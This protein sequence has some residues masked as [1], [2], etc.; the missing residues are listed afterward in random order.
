MNVLTVNNLTK[1][2]PSFKLDAVSFSL[3]EGKITGFIGRNGAGKST[4][5]NCLFNFVHSDS[6]E[7][8]FFGL[9]FKK[10]E[11]EIKEKIGFVSSGVN[12]YP[13]KK[14]KKISAV[15]KMFYN[16]WDDAAYQKYMQMFKL[17]EK[18]TPSQLSTGMKVKYALTLA[19][20]HNADLLILDEP[21]SGLDPVSRDDLLDVFMSLCDEGKTILFST[22]IISDLDKCADNIIYI[23]NGKIISE[24]AV[25]DF[26]NFYKLISFDNQ[27]AV[28]K[29]QRYLLG[30]KR[31]K[32]GYSALI[33]SNDAVHFD[34]EV[35]NAD[36]EAIMIH[37][38]KEAESND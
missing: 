29:Y 18:K 16:K 37:I 27:D 26:E 11:T 12:Y 7:I 4:T 32:D 28:T 25:K 22:H 3:E 36:L 23:K 14:I 19:L 21:T 13:N 30:I 24:K 1:S 17:D 38:E 20:S 34:C 8:S 15:T 35:H 6:G 10:S 9:D 2:Y 33:E 5:L 31:N